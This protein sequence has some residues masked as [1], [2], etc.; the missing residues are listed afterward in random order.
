MTL[1]GESQAIWPPKMEAEVE[2]KTPVTLSGKRT[3]ADQPLKRPAC[4]PPK[5]QRRVSSA[6]IS[7]E[8]IQSV[9]PFFWASQKSS[10]FF[11]TA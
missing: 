2:V 8:N 4:R 5:E 10:R 3:A 1:A 11:L 9:R 6:G 7:Q